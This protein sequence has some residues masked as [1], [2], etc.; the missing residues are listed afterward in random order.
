MF[1]TV[2]TLNDD[3]SGP[4]QAEPVVC[5]EVFDVEFEFSG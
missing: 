2:S 5:V 1:K 4:G 3:Q